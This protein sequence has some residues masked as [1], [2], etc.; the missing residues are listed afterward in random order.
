[1]KNPFF[2]LDRSESVS[3]SIEEMAKS[4]TP[5][6][7]ASLDQNWLKELSSRVPQKKVNNS[8]KAKDSLWKLTGTPKFRMLNEPSEANKPT[9]HWAGRREL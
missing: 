9:F 5:L 8:V 4:K 2:F 3:P 6:T 7:I 1:M